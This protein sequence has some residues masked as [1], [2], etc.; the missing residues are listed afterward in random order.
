MILRG[1]ASIAFCLLAIV[2]FDK[3]I[4]QVVNTTVGNYGVISL[5]FIH[6]IIMN[7]TLGPCC[8]I[9]C[10]EIVEDITWMIIMLKGLALMV[11]L[12]S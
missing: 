3:V 7:F 1:Q 12:T 4:S 6:L 10:T 11:A 2:I 9:Y 5:I 8:I